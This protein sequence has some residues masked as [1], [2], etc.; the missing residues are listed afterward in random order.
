LREIIG[1]EKALKT[2]GLNEINYGKWLNRK[3]K[4]A[5]NFLLRHSKFSSG[6]A[7]EEDTEEE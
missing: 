3:Q 5:N 1:I 7:G 2:I 4:V 6:T